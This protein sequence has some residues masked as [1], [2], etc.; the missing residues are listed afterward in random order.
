MT[1]GQWVHAASWSLPNLWIFLTFEKVGQLGSYKNSYRKKISDEQRWSSGCRLLAGD[2]YQSEHDSKPG[3]KQTK[4]ML[5]PRNEGGSCM[6]Q[7]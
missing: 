4:I 5:K 3:K 1:F 2:G 7:I 6:A